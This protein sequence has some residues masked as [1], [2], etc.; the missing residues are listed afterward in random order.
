MAVGTGHRVSR[1]LLARR[2]L[3]S[4]AAQAQ[5]QNDS[6]YKGRKYHSK[7]SEKYDLHKYDL[8]IVLTQKV[9]LHE[10]PF[11]H[12]HTHNQT[13]TDGE[14]DLHRKGTLLQNVRF[15]TSYQPLRQAQFI[16]VL[17]CVILIPLRQAQFT[18]VLLNTIHFFYDSYRL[19]SPLTPPTPA[20]C[21]SP[22][23]PERFHAISLEASM[24]ENKI[25]QRIF[26]PV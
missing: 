25:N 18:A 5:H 17:T 8:K 12:T 3:T 21:F 22:S 16:P 2:S 7:H 6:H 11:T 10:V 24:I 15:H 1:A 14:Y 26:T 23:Q 19:P 4:V 9:Q 13:Y 20:S